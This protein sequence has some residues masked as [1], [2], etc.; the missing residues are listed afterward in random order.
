MFDSLHTTLFGWSSSCDNSPNRNMFINCKN[1]SNLSYCFCRCSF[2][3]IFRLFSPTNNGVTVTNDD[4][5]FSP[6]INV[7]TV[8]D[9]F[10][11]YPTYGDRF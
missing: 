7:S 11:N 3:S 10:N 5:L 1:V 8:Y 4:G 2:A 6:L 9:M